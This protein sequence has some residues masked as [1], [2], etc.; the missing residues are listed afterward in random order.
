M[1]SYTLR[2]V[3]QDDHE[4]L[5][6]LH[7]DPNV[8]RNLIDPRPITLEQHLSWWSKVKDDPKQLRMIFEVDGLR[9]GFTKF[10]DIDHANRNCVLGADIHK[11]HRGKGY[12]EHMWIEMLQVCF[13]EFH[14]NLHRVGLS[15][16]SFNDVAQRVYRKLGFK[17]E[18]RITHHIFRD[19]QFW[20]GI[21]MYMLEED[22]RAK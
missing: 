15:T 22:W 13:G 7:N 18:G 10:Y 6:E 20:D 3:T 21:C 5:V 17:E 16:A 12:A 1:S 4:W 14:L 11:D 2:P 19:G 9:V 8:L